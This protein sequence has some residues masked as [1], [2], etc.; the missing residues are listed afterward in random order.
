MELLNLA[1]YEQR[2]AELLEPAALAYYAG[3]AADERTLADNRAAYDRW[4]LRPRV[5]VDVDEPSTSTTVLGHEVALPLLVAP[6]AYQRVVHPDG[7]LGLARAAADAGSIY[8]LST[9]A[10]TGWDEVATAGGRR[11]FQF[12]VPRDR[13]LQEEI[14]SGVKAAGF[15]AVVLTV[16]IPVLGRREGSLRNE[17]VIPFELG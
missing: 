14:L 12:Y 15:E 1:D 6:V 4:L 2:A 9:F 7:E 17:L 5:L 11:W 8:C 13:A 10:T 3:G 16:D